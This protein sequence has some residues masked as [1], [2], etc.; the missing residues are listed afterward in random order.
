MSSIRVTSL[1]KNYRKYKPFMMSSIQQALAYR[2]SVYLWIFSKILSLFV[3]YYLWKAIYRNDLSTVINGFSFPEMV[4]YIVISYITVNIISGNAARNIAYDVVEGSIAINLIKPIS[5][6]TK[7]L[8]TS[9]GMIIFRFFVPGIF[10]WGGV[11][12]FEY[13]EYGIYPPSIQ[14]TLLYLLSLVFSFL[15]MFLFDFCYGMLAFYTTY[16]WGMNM[17]KAALLLFL[18]GSMIPLSF[19]PPMAQRIFEFLPFSSMNYVPVM[20][21]LGKISGQALM[22]AFLVQVVWIAILYILS[23]YF[24]KKA[25]KRLTVVGG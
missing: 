19:F 15:I 1:R 24:W 8:F 23:N 5:Y 6:R 21:Y 4:I 18:S 9:F 22:K 2:G 17:S 13:H 3:T 16:V 11:L 7:L 25:T 12:F 20:I 10:L 14:L